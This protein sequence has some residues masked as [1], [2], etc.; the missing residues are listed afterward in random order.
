[1]VTPTRPFDPMFGFEVQ[2]VDAL[3]L[4]ETFAFTGGECQTLRSGRVTC[5][6][7]DGTQSAQFEPLKAKPDRVRFSFRTAT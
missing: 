1:M 6:T 7:I 5:K 3:A 2:V 4:D